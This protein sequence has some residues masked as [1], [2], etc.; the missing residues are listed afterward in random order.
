[1]TKPVLSLLLTALFGLQ[2]H[3][4]WADEAKILVAPAK[5]Q[6][7]P[8]LQVCKQV[9]EQG[10]VVK[11]DANGAL[12]IPFDNFWFVIEVDEKEMRCRYYRHM[13]DG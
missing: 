3:P 2:L 6:P 1:M 11:I 8:S 13:M 10:R 5:S 4:S 9:L 12:H 7:M